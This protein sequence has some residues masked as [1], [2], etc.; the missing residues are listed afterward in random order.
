MDYNLILALLL[1][2]SVL[3]FL[4]I[5]LK[6]Q[7]F[8]SLLIASITVGIVA[9]M[10]P[11]EMMKTIQTGMANTL[12]FVATV[13]G[14]GAMFGAILEHSGGAKI[15]SKMMLKRFGVEKAPIAMVITGFIIAIPV[16]FEVAFILLIPMIYALQKQTGKS[17]LTFAIPLLA[18]LAVTHA[19]IPPTP[20][21]IAVADIIGVDLG[22]VILIGA[23]VGVPSALV[24]G[25]FF[26][27]YISKK[28]FA[29]VPF[30]FDSEE[31]TTLSP[32]F[33]T[34]ITI[35]SVPIFLILLNTFISSNLIQI[36][37]SLIV[38]FIQLIGHPFS[39]L[40][41]A[42]I[43]AWY[44]L[45]IKQGF[46]KAQLLKITTKSMEPAGI[47][48]LVTG[49][50]GV[51]KQFLVNTGVGEMLAESLAG[52][53]FPVLVFSFIIAS[54]VRITQGSATVAM[55]TAAGLVSPLLSEMNYENFDLA[56]IVISIAAGS[57]IFSHVN[58]SGFWL[59]N[60]YLG[61][62]EKDT[63]RSWT[64]MTTILALVGFSSV[65]ILSAIF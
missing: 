64:M 62:S 27:K 9:G 63:F 6:I 49:A 51:F 60:Q 17:I 47:I 56:C 42:N 4:I 26:G 30:E 52:V 50:G 15:I 13:V 37:S 14:L 58:D 18:G 32:S 24:S 41:I 43:L 2:I 23:I 34:V 45:G 3:L 40:I 57:S 65:C 54:L 21:P 35:I 20:G 1:G 7:A 28:I 5:K 12:G 38:K 59:V 33:S 11:E 8:I 31:H 39:A 25:L 44:I 55:I 22:W 19:F 36:S 16:F 53:G 29:A 46:T 48:I 10:Q 61:L